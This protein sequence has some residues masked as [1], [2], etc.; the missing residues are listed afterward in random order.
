LAE[1]SSVRERRAISRSVGTSLSLGPAATSI[2]LLLGAVISVLGWLIARRQIEIE[3]ARQ[4][5]LYASTLADVVEARI[6]S[7][8]QALHRR[9]ELWSDPQRPGEFWEPSVDLFLLENPSLL[10]LAHSDASRPVLGS[11]EGVRVLTQLMP[12]IVESAQGSE[13]DVVIGPLVLDGRPLFGLR[14]KTDLASPPARVFAAFD[15]SV[16]LR[17]LLDERALGYGIRVSVGDREL[18]R[19]PTNGSPI[20]AELVQSDSVSLGLGSAWDLSIWPIATTA[21]SFYQQGPLLVLVSGLLASTLIA[22]AV[23]YGTLAWR[24]ADALR[25][26]NLLLER[27]I[28]ETQ[29]GQ[30]DLRHLSEELEARVAQRTAELND[31]IVELETFNYSVSH[32]LRGPLGA[33]INFAAILREDYESRLDDAG[34]DIL[35][36]IVQSSAA[37]VSM[38]DALLAYSRSG[39]SELRKTRL[40]VAR[41]VREVEQEFVATSQQFACAVKI[42]DLPDVVADENMLRFIFANLISN[43][44]KFARSGES[45]SVEIGGHVSGGEA[46]FHVRDAGVGFDMRFAEKLFKVFERLHPSDDYPG[47]G[48]G[49]AIVAR[50]VRRHGGRVWAQGAVG[51]GATFYFTIPVRDG[52][53]DGTKS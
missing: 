11:A 28:E 6:G 25:D 53:G 21:L 45:P 51:K 30:G 39:R 31:T 40:D 49:L 44:C 33:V 5:S 20:P 26:A 50:M 46:V 35:A 32:D 38:M 10:A 2:I 29:R 12:S 18:Y 42:G 15:P 3:M 17:E 8:Y 37:A 48:V 43:A 41:L 22:F 14:V 19:R 52:S 1:V 9:A 36:R 47:H 13:G 16:A 7:L 4:T 34:R 23:H 27:Q 24:R